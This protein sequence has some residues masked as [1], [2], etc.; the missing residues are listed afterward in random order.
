M[1]HATPATAVQE[2]SA[3]SPPLPFEKPS[4]GTW[5]FD[6]S[7]CERP[8][9]RIMWGVLE[10]AFTT[11]NREGCASYGILFDTVE[12][13][14]VNGFMYVCARP[15]GGPP[16]PRSNPPKF[17]FKLMF[18]LHPG[19]RRRLR[20][21][22]EA[23][24]NRLWREQTA[25][26]LDQAAAIEERLQELLAVDL[27]P[28]DDRALVDHLRKCR[29]L[30]EDDASIHYRVNMSRL[31]PVGDLMVHV[32]RWTEVEISEILQAL[33]GT[34]PNSEEG[35][36]ELE[37][38][39]SL[40]RAD[41]QACKLLELGEGQ[42]A[43]AI[44]QS[45]MER[46]DEIGNAIRA[47]LNRIGHRTSGFSVGYPTLREMPATLLKTLRAAADNP[48]IS[49]GESSGKEACARLRERIPEPHRDSFDALME[50]ARSVYFL[51]DHCTQRNT[52]TFGLLRIAALEVGRRLQ[53][54][55]K[56]SVP[57][58]ALDLRMEDIDEALTDRGVDFDEINRWYEWRRRASGELAPEI[59]GPAPLDPP[60]MD[61]FPDGA[62]RRLTE[63]IMSYDHAMNDEVA[64]EA[65]QSAALVQGM[66]ASPGKHR[67]TA[68]LV[69][70]PGDFDK[71]RP[72]DILI[73]RMTA[74]SYNVLLP[75]L[76]G[77]VT[78]RGGMLSHPAIVSREYGIPGV[79][80]T[81]CA[82]STI[83]DGAMVEIDGD[84]G[85]VRLLA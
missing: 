69:L 85:T 53:E 34:S 78:D 58:A 19:I 49:D 59:L 8:L 54:R 45:L 28:L 79:V 39:A 31:I 14:L 76:A 50:E 46:Q 4:P 22:E 40:V 13:Q 77:V 3:P 71:V 2:L 56:L 52:A 23:L 80:G 9:P 27:G 5:M 18:A 74:P 68:R 12:L 61:W 48:R 84:A 55:G 66:P 17:V 6:A 35:L 16:E 67:G 51:R 73:A 7:H 20:I 60:P 37:A 1:N 64:A 82:T 70:N 32:T 81:R 30:A 36:A 62:N 41:A 11:G 83:P 72:G 26:Y 63:A 25:T 47:W 29:K 57:E 43:E 10:H 21:S 24:R 44:V 15:L 42:D 33:R 38:L 75:M 65:Q